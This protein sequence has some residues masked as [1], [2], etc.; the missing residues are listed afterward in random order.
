MTAITTS[1]ESAPKKTFRDVWII[2]AA[3][4]LTHWY[5][6]TF[7]LLLPLIGKELGLSYSQIGLVMTCQYAAGAIAN[8]PGGMVVETVGRKGFLMAL[9][10]FWVGFPYLLIGFTHNYAML[11]L[12]MSLVGIGNNLWHPTAIPTLANKYPENKGLVL[13]IHGMGGNIG[14]ALA[15]LAIGTL[16]TILTWREIVV[17]NVIPGLLMSGLL[18]M[19]LGSVTIGRK[20]KIDKTVEAFTPGQSM[21]EYFAGLKELLKN[22]N[23]IYLSTSSAFR[24][25]TQNALLTFLPVFLAYEMHYNPFWVGLCLFMMQAA[26]FAA[27]P[28]SGHLSDKMGRRQVIMVSMGMTALVLLFMAFAGRSAAFVFFIAVLGFFLYAIRPVLQAWLLEST[29]KNMGGTSIGILF[30]VQAAGSAISPLIGGYLAD[31]YGLMSTFYFLA[32]TIVIA[33]MFIFL[34]PDMGKTTPGLKVSKH[35]R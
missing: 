17:V 4:S 26:G 2:T 16:L 9:S 32:G 13:S 33:N 22:R 5:P 24:A 35:D 1:P 27:S 34:M 3:H 12:C 10:L 14:D 8:V 20:K 31:K 11:L 21:K 18:M 19:F 28:I 15:P 23:L 25:M 29:P 6:A 30:A 7:Y